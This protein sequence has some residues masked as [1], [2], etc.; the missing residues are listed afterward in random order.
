MVGKVK[1]VIFQRVQSGFSKEN[2]RYFYV[3][4]L[5]EKK[6]IYHIFA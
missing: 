3:N 1:Y 2:E 4:C 6:K 5:H